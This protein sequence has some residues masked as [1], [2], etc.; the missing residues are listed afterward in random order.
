MPEINIFNND[1]NFQIFEPGEVIFKRGEQSDLMYA[2]IE[3]EIDIMVD[4]KTIDTAYAGSLIGE[5]A[6][7]DNSP[8]SA[9]AQARTRAKVVPVTQKR[10]LFMVQQT[11]FFSIQVM[12]IMADRLRRLMES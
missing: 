4:G 8:R 5:M 1:S 11:P 6:L 3:G 10:F 9:T 2:V 7:I 12:R